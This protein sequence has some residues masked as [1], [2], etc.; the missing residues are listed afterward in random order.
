MKVLG[1]SGSLR[2][3]SYN[4]KL[5]RAAAELLPR[6]RGV[7]AVGRPE[8]GAALRRGRRRR[9]GAGGRRCAS[10][11]DRRR[12]RRPLRDARVQRVDS[13][14]AEE[15]ARL[16]LAPAR[17]RTPCGTSPSRSS[18]RAPAPSARSGRRPSCGRCWRRSGPASSRGTSRSGTRQTRFDEDGRLDRRAAARAAPGG[19]LGARRRSLPPSRSHSRPRP[20]ADRVVGHG[21]HL[22]PVRRARRDAEPSARDRRRPLRRAAARAARRRRRL[23]DADAFREANELRAWI[24]VEDGTDRR[25][26]PRR[27]Q[28]AAPAPGSTRRRPDRLPGGRV[29]GP[30]AGARVGDGWVRFQQTVGGRI[31]LPVP[32]TAA[33]QALLPHRLGAGLDDAGAGH[34]R[35]RVVGG[36]ARRG[37]PVSAPLDL[38][39]RTASWSRSME[40]PTSTAGTASRSRSPRGAAASSRRS[41]TRSCCEAAARSSSGAGSD[42]ERCSSSRARPAPTCSCSSKACSRSRSTARPSRESAR[43]RARRARGARRREAHSD[44]ARGP[45]VARSRAGGHLTPG[46]ARARPPHRRLAVVVHELD[47]V[48]VGIEDERAVVALVVHPAARPGAPLSR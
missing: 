26:R 28:L 10:R 2:D 8:G 19:R 1:I 47:V 30:P 42:A 46:R 20:D 14:R 9:A 7:R 40:S 36:Q 41:S 13:R 24:E 31:G 3:D 32:Q 27:A 35:R 48:A 45:R 29:P 18:A 38:R 34:P 6:R 11:G 43:A 17:G 23:R 5:L 22:A 4:T 21:D 33:R 12:R 16:G 25:L 15:R 37:E 44:A 39:R